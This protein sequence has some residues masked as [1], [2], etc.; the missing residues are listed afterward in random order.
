M[1]KSI[2]TN[3]N[4]SMQKMEITE[5]LGVCLRYYNKYLD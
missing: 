2:V 5:L 3:G 1:L 4:I